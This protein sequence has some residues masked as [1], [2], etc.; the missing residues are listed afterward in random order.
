MIGLRDS[1]VGTNPDLPAAVV[2]ILRKRKHPIHVPEP[3]PLMAHGLAGIFPLAPGFAQVHRIVAPVNRPLET[4]DTGRGTSRRLGMDRPEA[5]AAPGAKPKMPVEH[6][7]EPD[8]GPE[9]IGAVALDPVARVLFL[10]PADALSPE[11]HPVDP[12]P[13]RNT[14]SRTETAPGIGQAVIDRR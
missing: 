13:G 3:L 10:V 1:L 4:I 6:S 11:P 2:I 7:I 8:H 9:R 12:I 14:G 5:V